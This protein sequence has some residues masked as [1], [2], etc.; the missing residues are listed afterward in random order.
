[1]AP[2]EV[3]SPGGAVTS[4]VGREPRPNG[5]TAILAGVFG[6]LLAVLLGY[7]PLKFFVDYS[8]DGMDGRVRGVL[9]I[10]A[11]AAL[12]LLA[13]ALVT[14]FRA[15][16]GAV[17][18]LVGGLLAVAAVVLEPVLLYPGYFGD[19]FSAMFRFA[20]DDA[21]VR[22]GAAVGGPVVFVLAVLPWTF[23]YLRHRPAGSW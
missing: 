21:F 8:F 7:L 23:R 2:K 13:G 4:P 1:M 22:V 9:G 5:T 18:L 16:T 6:L 19:F 12:V 17:L 3:R 15:V 14:F 20:P 10:Y 11:A